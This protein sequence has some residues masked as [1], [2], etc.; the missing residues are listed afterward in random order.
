MKRIALAAALAA[1]ALPTSAGD[2]QP[3][4]TVTWKFSSET[5]TNTGKKKFP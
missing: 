4:T 1:L 2:T 5:T 3:G